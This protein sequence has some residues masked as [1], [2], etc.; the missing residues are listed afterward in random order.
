MLDAGAIDAPGASSRYHCASRQ[1]EWKHVVGGYGVEGGVR[2]R[3]AHEWLVVSVSSHRCGGRMR[4]QFRGRHALA[5]ECEW[6][7]WSGPRA[8]GLSF[9]CF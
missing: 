2:L 3:K 4:P 6:G 1:Y 5:A 8:W 7:C 9:M